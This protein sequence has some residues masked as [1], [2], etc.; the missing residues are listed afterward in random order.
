M[1][2]KQKFIIDTDIGDEIDDAIAISCA[3]KRGFSL[4]GVTTVFLNTL[5]RARQIKKLMKAFGNGYENVPV[6]AGY[7][8][9]FD[10]EPA[11]YPFIP[12]RTPDL[13]DEKYAPN[14][15][16]PE[17]AVDFI[18]DSCRKYK[19]EL[20]VIAIGPFTNIAK[21][22]K[23]DPEA[24][25]MA[26]NV[27][28]MGGAYYKQYADWNVMCD[29]TAAD[30]M[31]KGLDNLECIGADVTHLMEGEPALYDSMFNYSGNNEGRQY[32]RELCR[33]W[34][35]DRPNSKFLLHDPLVIYYADDKSLCETE[36]APIAVLTDG[37]A[38]GITL[39]INAYSK[40]RLNPVAYADFDKSHTARVA[41][42]ADRERFNERIFI[43]FNH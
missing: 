1:S 14:S 36:E 41:K 4:H 21:A 34:K 9:P 6:L 5:D 33:L 15:I 16:D 10:S 32:L 40:K 12:R 7:G 2:D 8:V 23:K 3:M 17:A 20:T 29:V 37:F 39:N 28:I 42:T 35:A 43:D 19:D 38:K 13:E 25:N 30:V 22:I 26:K 31:F 24:L 27:I 11:T 18:I